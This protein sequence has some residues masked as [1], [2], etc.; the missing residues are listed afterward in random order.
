[1]RLCNELICLNYACIIVAWVQ[2]NHVTRQ[3]K[4][5]RINAIYKKTKLQLKY[6]YATEIE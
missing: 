3:P 5:Q 6:R 1:M 2:D 4:T